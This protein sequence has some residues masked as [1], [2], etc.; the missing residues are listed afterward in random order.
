MNKFFPFFLLMTVILIASCERDE[1]EVVKFDGTPYIFVYPEN[2]DDPEL[3]TDNVL[4]IEGVK[5][6]KMLFYE[7]SLSKDGTQACA[8]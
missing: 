8:T 2:F 4:T 6:G 3:P 5:L 1:V 7:K